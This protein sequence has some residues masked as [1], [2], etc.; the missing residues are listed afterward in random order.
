MPQI[1][2]Y[3]SAHGYGHGVRST[4]VIRALHVAEPEVSV[5]V[6]S[7]LDPSFLRNRL[8]ASSVRIRPGAF[9][10]GMV[11]L[12]SI[13]VD[14]AASLERVEALHARRADL[15]AS[16][17]D[18]LAAGG[19]DL[20]VADIP[21]I[22]IEAAKKA[23]ITAVAVASFGWDWI[24]GEFADRDERWAA[25]AATVARGYAEADLLLRLPFG[26][27]MPAFPRSEDLPVL[28]SPGRPRRGEI[29]QLTG[30]DPSRRWVLICFTSLEWSEEALD[31]VERLADCSFI[32]VAPLGW[33]RRNFHTVERERIPFWD[34]VASV[35]AVISKPGYGIL[36]DCVVN[37]K[38]L[39]YSEREDF[40]EYGVIEP[41]I[42]RYVRHLKI[43][44]TQLYSGDLRSAIDALDGLPPPPERIP[45]GGAALAAVRLLGLCAR[46]R[47]AI[48]VPPP[49][50]AA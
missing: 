13:R 23:G 10:V 16:E 25:A 30:A 21:A 29:S 12:D 42:R 40:R 18:F 32:T 11:Q 41:A 3:I 43:P 27:A 36:S 8:P 6:V 48:R 39:I 35:D 4:D 37:G 15:I 24:Y 45:A 9:D 5:L 17:A 14:V 28:A 19:Y 38:P 47:P 44:V 31:R 34:V 49:E 26:E 50:G 22:P 2:W 33:A 7:D 20:A 46:G 1:A